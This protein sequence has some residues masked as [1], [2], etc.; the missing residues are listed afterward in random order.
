MG[1]MQLMPGTAEE[2]GVDDPF[3]AEQNVRGGTRY[4]RAMIDR[5]GDLGAR[6]RRVQRRARRRSI[7]TAASRRTAETRDYVDRVLTYYRRYHGDFAR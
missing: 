1:L 5:Y 2:L 3:R 6:A 7:A 4:L